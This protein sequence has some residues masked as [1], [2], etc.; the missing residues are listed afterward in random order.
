MT[1][2][3]CPSSSLS[4]TTSS[5]SISSP[6]TISS[7][8]LKEA[9]SKVEARALST[10]TTLE[11][12]NAEKLAHPNSESDGS[13]ADVSASY[14]LI[15][16][17][18]KSDDAASSVVATN[19]D[20]SNQD[21]SNKSNTFQIASVSSQQTSF[22]QVSYQDADKS[23]PDQNNESLSQISPSNLFP[24]SSI[25][26]NN[27]NLASFIKSG[28][29]LA[30]ASSIDS[31]PI[32]TTS[33]NASLVLSPNSLSAQTTSNNPLEALKNTTNSISQSTPLFVFGGAQASTSGS[34][35]SGQTSS[36]EGLFTFGKTS[37]TSPVNSS[38][39]PTIDS[40]NKTSTS[41]VIG[42]TITP[43]EKSKE[44]I[45]TTF[46]NEKKSEG[47]ISFFNVPTTSSESDNKTT[48][49][50]SSGM[51]TFS[52]SNPVAAPISSTP[53]FTL[54][55][56]KQ[57]DTGEKTQPL[58]TS[59]FSFGTSLSN[60]T[61][62]TSSASIAPATSNIFTF[63]ATKLESPATTSQNSD[64]LKPAEN[65]SNLMNS[66][67]SSA[68]ALHTKQIGAS[69]PTT[70]SS[71]INITTSLFPAGNLSNNNNNTSFS[72]GS[73]SIKT[74]LTPAFSK[75]AGGGFSFGDV[76]KA[77]TQSTES[78]FSFAT[79]NPIQTPI[80]KDT[81]GG[82]FNSEVNKGTAAT[83]LFQF[84][85]NNS[86]GSSTSSNVFTFGTT[87]GTPKQ[88]TNGITFNPPANTTTT[89]TTT[90]GSSGNSNVFTFGSNTNT[91]PPSLFGT[92]TLTSTSTAGG[93]GFGVISPKPSSTPFNFGA[94]SEKIS[95]PTFGASQ[96]SIA[97]FG[98]SDKPKNLFGGDNSNAPSNPFG[99]SSN[100]PA[101][102]PFGGGS[103][104][105]N[106]NSFGAAK[107]SAVGAPSPT[108][109]IFGSPGAGSNPGTFSSPTPTPPKQSPFQIN[110][111]TPTPIAPS[112]FTF[113]QTN[114][115]S[116]SAQSGGVFMFGSGGAPPSGTGGSAP[117]FG[118]GKA[119]LRSFG[120]P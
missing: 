22:S 101:L 99:G 79:S 26:A 115:Q 65:V 95:I 48:F 87:S 110:P 45:T 108:F 14:T 41:L 116:T 72:F 27:N 29:Q 12:N 92:N 30:T 69:S 78:P 107:P 114:Q 86:S 7:G 60:T 13:S 33:A 16:K 42:Q 9:I 67:I 36:S 85:V 19:K 118:S 25:T 28:E 2:L 82:G 103:P 96:P 31:A 81:P 57:S 83:T 23:L 52:A 56:T 46:Q 47:I 40:A 59:P 105:L 113:G 39:A 120:R 77:S 3:S 117:S 17:P 51:F 74:S 21:S 61:V 5:H 76:S 88:E 119:S 6:I 4:V 54:K 24:S 62:Q 89:T 94:T 35:T 44:T 84:G 70:S 111:G 1:Q 11:Q 58:F 98:S 73:N 104:G 34:S 15:L 20:L 97:S 64:G 37:T 10:P 75:T 53:L 63:G 8:L 100:T 90:T 106:Q 49:A 71:A 38:T 66:A 112:T 32:C 80:V 93:G 55:D 102:S 43:S 18:N 109:G 50:S 91:K 68:F